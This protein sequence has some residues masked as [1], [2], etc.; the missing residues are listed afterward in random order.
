[1]NNS[2]LVM[3]SKHVILYLRQHYLQLQMW[4][5][6]V[7]YDIKLWWQLPGLPYRRACWTHSEMFRQHVPRVIRWHGQNYLH[8]HLNVN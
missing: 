4:C 1:M 5:Y 3:E 6:F 7:K 8:L 2:Y